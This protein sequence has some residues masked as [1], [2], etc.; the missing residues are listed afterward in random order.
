MTVLCGGVLLEPGSDVGA[1]RERLGQWRVFNEWE[2][3]FG[4]P[5]LSVGGLVRWYCEAWEL[6]RRYSPGWQDAGI[7]MEKIERI[8]R[9]REAF[10]C[11]G[12]G[13]AAVS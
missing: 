5:P 10:S 4:D 7:D 1:L 6:S 11:L 3:R 13:G 8:R 2:R 12:G 9:M